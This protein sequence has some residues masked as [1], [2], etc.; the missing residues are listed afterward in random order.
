[1]AGTKIKLMAMAL[2]GF[3]LAIA[4][5]L[6]ATAGPAAAQAC[7]GPAGADGCWEMDFADDFDGTSLD[8]AA[9]E[10][11]WYVDSG[12]SRSVADNE[13]ACY[14][15]DQVTVSGGALRIRLDPST[16]PLCLDKH[17]DV[18]P[19]VGGLINSR[20]ALRDADHPVQLTG[21]YFVEARIKAPADGQTM[22]NWPAFWT[23]GGSP[24]PTN[25]E[26]DILEGLRGEAKYNYHYLCGDTNCQ[27]GAEAYPAA[28]IDGDW[29]VYAAERRIAV[30]S[31]DGV[32]RATITY[33]LDGVEIGQVTENVTESQQYI[34]LDYTSHQSH[35]TTRTGES[36]EVDWVRAWS[37]S[38][39][40]PLPPFS[41]EVDAG[42]V[43]WT[44]HGVGKYWVYRSVDG[45]AAF[46]WIGR[47]L[48][49]T[50]FTDRTPS[51]GAQY[52]VHYNGIPRIACQ[53]NSEPVD[54]LPPFACQ[55]DEVAG[56]VVLSWTDHEVGKYWV[57][58][59]VDNGATFNWIGR[60]FGATV[61][62]D[63][64]PVAGSMYQV[65]YN[66]I[67]R[68]ACSA[69]D[70]SCFATT[71]G[72]DVIVTFDGRRGASENL[73]TTTSWVSGVTGQLAYSVAGG[74]GDNYVVRLR[75]NGWTGPNGYADRA[76]VA[77]N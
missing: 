11:G 13:D 12:Y 59:S 58:R 32:E 43:S 38:P 37:P 21:T 76:C 9:W 52:Q 67:P 57:Y 28:A 29:H 56:E 40:A 20:D 8:L 71:V 10:P 34:I 51:I 19:Y 27:V 30:D 60:T 70:Y 25:G 45:G 23:N 35:G 49:E 48:G 3:G 31:R 65:H 68:T 73:R 55:V 66:G 61:F 74:A 46:N 15:T 77:R 22:W 53:V 5:G 47:T 33:F 42:E 4:A 41:C 72:P 44:D 39:A 24:W 63:A 62:A 1:M 6:L 54:V 26:I 2:M 14:N 16:N 64:A 17:G 50:S 7:A 18:A 36:L 69:A 75:G